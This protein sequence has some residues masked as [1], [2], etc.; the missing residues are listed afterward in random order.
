[1]CLREYRSILLDR[2]DED[3]LVYTRDGAGNVIR[4]AILY[5]IILLS[6]PSY[7]PSIA[8]TLRH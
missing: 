6:P 4:A 7:G 2:S 8:L 5:I 3:S 1:M